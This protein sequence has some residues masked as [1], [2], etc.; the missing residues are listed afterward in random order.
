MDDMIWKICFKCIV[1][2]E[3]LNFILMPKKIEGQI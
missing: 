3:A 2:S 1:F